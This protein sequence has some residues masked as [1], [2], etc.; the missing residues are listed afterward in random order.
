MVLPVQNDKQEIENPDPQN[1]TA[2]PR[3]A[4]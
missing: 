3:T 1:N 4:S 2:N